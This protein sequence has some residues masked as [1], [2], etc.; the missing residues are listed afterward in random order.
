MSQ[1]RYAEEAYLG[2]GGLHYAARWNVVGT[3]LAYASE[4]LALAALEFFVNWNRRVASEPLAA[5]PAEIPDDLK[6]VALDEIALPANWRAVSVPESTQRIGSDW[7]RS[8]RST[9]LSVPSVLIP[10]ERNYLLNPAH[11]DFKR[12]RIGKPEPF[13]FDH[14]M[15]KLK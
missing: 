10:Q 13:S 11:R 6:I 1:A 4:S 12:L 3:C 8:G 14:R 15:W 5:V 2:V 7:V 9:V